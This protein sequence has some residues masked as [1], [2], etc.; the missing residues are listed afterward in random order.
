MILVKII[1][2]YFGL[3][4]LNLVYRFNGF[5]LLLVKEWIENGSV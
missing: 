5:K 2:K 3:G 1:M 4:F